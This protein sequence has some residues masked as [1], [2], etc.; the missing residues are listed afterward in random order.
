MLGRVVGFRE[1]LG[2]GIDTGDRDG[3]GCGGGVFWLGVGSIV[4]NAI[5]GICVG[6][7]VGLLG[8]LAA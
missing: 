4:G 5:D 7:R 1:G 3:K 8:G 6:L 2:D